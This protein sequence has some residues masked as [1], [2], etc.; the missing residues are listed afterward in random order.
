MFITA[1]QYFMWLNQ[2]KYIQCPTR[3]GSSKQIILLRVS[4]PSLGG[5]SE[6]IPIELESNDGVIFYFH[7]NTNDVPPVN[8]V[9]TDF[10][11]LLY[12]DDKHN[13]CWHT[14]KCFESRSHLPESTE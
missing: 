12:L 10:R 6:Y 2:Y 11:P 14:N 8:E 7:P 9:H 3:T 13:M 1:H 5:G 4:P